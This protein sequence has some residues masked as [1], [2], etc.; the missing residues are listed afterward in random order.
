MELSIFEKCRK[1]ALTLRFGIILFALALIYA[2]VCTPIYLWAMNDIAVLETVFPTVWDVIM[3]LINYA[4][5]WIAFAFL[6]FAV[7]RFLFRNCA[8]PFAVTGAA[9]VFRYLANL[10][11]AGVS[12]GFTSLSASDFGYAVLDIVL[13]LVQVSLVGLIA[14]LSMNRQQA[15]VL[16]RRAVE[17]YKGSGVTVPMPEW[18]PIGRLFDFRNPLAF[19]AFLAAMV[20][21]LI[22]LISRMIYDFSLFGP[23]QNT[24]DA[25]WMVVYYVSD[26]LFGFLGFLAITLILNHTHDGEEKRKELFDRETVSG[27]SL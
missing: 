5:Y 11:A 25:L 6:L 21:A 16:R 24:A 17:T 22:K 27:N 2:A 3:N 18:L 14:F 15:D 13:D 4:F 19:A 26:L 7:S 10:V 1:K 8:A 23:A 9:V 20:P 12:E